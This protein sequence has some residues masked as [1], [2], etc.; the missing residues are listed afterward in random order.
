MKFGRVSAT[1]Y[2]NH[3]LL[4]ILLLDVFCSTNGT[5]QNITCSFQQLFCA[6]CY[7]FVTISGVEPELLRAGKVF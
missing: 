4:R 2:S 1:P 6:A 3:S 5:L 7:V